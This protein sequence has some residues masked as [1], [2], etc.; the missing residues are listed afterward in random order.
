MTVR[1]PSAAGFTAVLSGGLLCGDCRCAGSC[2]GGIR[3]VPHREPDLP[4]VL[5]MLNSAKKVTPEGINELMV[6][7]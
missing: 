5:D 4:D 2:Q 1:P 6:I 3:P 7:K